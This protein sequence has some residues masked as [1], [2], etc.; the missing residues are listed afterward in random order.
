MRQEGTFGR[1][2]FWTMGSCF[3]I[4]WFAGLKTLG[5]DAWTDLGKGG[6]EEPLRL[7]LGGSCP[8]IGIIYHTYQITPC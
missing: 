5:W 8:F 6:D 3:M 4:S 2:K 7:S 1:A